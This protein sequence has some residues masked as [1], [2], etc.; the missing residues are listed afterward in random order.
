MHTLWFPPFAILLLLVC[1]SQ[2]RL[3]DSLLAISD[4][5][6]VT[7]SKENEN[8]NAA[9]KTE[10]DVRIFKEYLDTIHGDE[11]STCPAKNPHEIHLCGQEKNGDSGVRTIL[12]QSY[13]PWY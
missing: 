4:D 5:D 1:F 13:H 3:L 8:Q 2:W 6:L 10:Y 11:T 7:F 12:N 9:E